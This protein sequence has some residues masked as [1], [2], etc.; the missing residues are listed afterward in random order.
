M[1]GVLQMVLAP[2]FKILFLLVSATLSG[3]QV[4]DAQG[5]PGNK[6][7]GDALGSLELSTRAEGNDYEYRIG[8][9]DPNC[10]V[11]FTLNF[12]EE[13]RRIE[14]P[15]CGTRAVKLGP[16]QFIDGRNHDRAPETR[17]VRYC[18]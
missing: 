16:K 13:P 6:C 15:T 4:A 2:S 5:S 14:P 9:T 18:Q 11:C 8:N 12:C 1:H 10:S 17:S 3:I 7:A